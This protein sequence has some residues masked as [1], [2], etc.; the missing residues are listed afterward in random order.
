MSH[1]AK[2]HFGELKIIRNYL[3]PPK[4]FKTAILALKNK[5]ITDVYFEN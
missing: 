1:S 5:I 2:K 3:R 4:M